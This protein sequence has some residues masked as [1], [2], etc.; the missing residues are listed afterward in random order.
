M[1]FKKIQ[2][3]TSSY[4]KLSIWGYSILKKIWNLKA[5]YTNYNYP[6]KEEIATI[7]YNTVIDFNKNR[8]YGPKKKICYAPFNNMHFQINGDVSAC[9]FN[10]DFLLG[11][12]NDHT[13]KEIWSGEKA[14]QFREKLGNY[15][16][17]FCKSCEFVLQAKNYNAF[18]PLKYDIHADDNINYPNQMSFEMSDLCNFE[19]VMCNEN[20]SSLIRKKKGLSPQKFSYPERFFEQLQEFLPHLKIATFIG[21][22]PLLIKSY[23]RIWEDILKVNKRCTIHI[24]TNASYLPPRFLEMLN[25]GQFDV[26]ISLDAANKET[27]EQIRINSNFEQIQANIN[28]LKSYMDKGKVNLN[29]NFCPLVIN[30]F[31]L[32]KMVTNC[33]ELNI[34]LKIVNVENPRHLSLHHRNA[35]F[36]DKVIKQLE[37]NS[38]NKSKSIVCNKNILSYTQFIQQLKHLKLEAIHRDNY[39]L[40][41]KDDIRTIFKDFCNNTSIFNNF[42]PEQRDI[43]HTKCLHHVQSLSTNSIIQNKTIFRVYY[44]L[45]N[46]KHTNQGESSTNFEYGCTVLLNVFDEFYTLVEEEQSLITVPN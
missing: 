11:N 39:Y 45:Y 36:I 13:I 3:I 2:K 20:F 41:I 9:S 1:D 29:I 34:P 24:Q 44:S 7:N 27:F 23:F 18:P 28:V 14:N 32:P 5:D 21:G 35:T 19:C 15:N 10:Y 30:W 38:F 17:E 22:E 43:I 26:G 12:V 6:K 33:N 37:A 42:S 16:F 25:T 31:E 8:P 46:I 4:P 40:D